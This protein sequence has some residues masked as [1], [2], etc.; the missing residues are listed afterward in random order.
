MYAYIYIY[1]YIT[2]IYVSPLPPDLPG[3]RELWTFWRRTEKKRLSSGVRVGLKGV[4]NEAMVQ[5]DRAKRF[6]V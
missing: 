4:A 5:S 3:H 2:L 6:V 1:I